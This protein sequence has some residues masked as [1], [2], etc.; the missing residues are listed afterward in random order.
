[1]VLV[2][3]TIMLIDAGPTAEGSVAKTGLQLVSSLPAVLWVL[4]MSVLW[5][6]A[7]AGMVTDL[8]SNRSAWAIAPLPRT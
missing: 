4:A 8:L 3:A 1:M 2:V 7:C 6:F 5:G